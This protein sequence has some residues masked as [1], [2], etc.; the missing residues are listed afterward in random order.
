MLSGL[1]FFPK[2][3]T[4]SNISV[5]PSDVLSLMKKKITLGDSRAFLLLPLFP[6][7]PTHNVFLSLA[8]KHSKLRC[9]S[10]KELRARSFHTK[11]F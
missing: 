4:V 1:L 9:K 5:L 2:W 10:R 6:N 3:P 8:R 11:Y 7:T